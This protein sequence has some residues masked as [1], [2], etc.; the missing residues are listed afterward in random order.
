[1]NRRIFPQLLL[2]LL[3]L[4]SARLSPAQ[5]NL[6]EL[7][8]RVKP[9]IV[10]IVTYGA[11]GTALT[12]G[13]GFFLRPGQVVTNLHVIRGARR[14]EVKTLDGKGRVYQVS[15][16]LAVDEEGDLALLSVE[17]PSGRGRSSELA[18][19]LP[20]EGEKIFVIGNPLKLEGSV[21]DGI[22]S[23]VRELP[24]IG[25]IIQITAPI[26]HGNSGS[27]VFNLKGQ[28]VGVVTIKVTNGQNINL[29]I[30]AARVRQLRP[31]KRRLL[32]ELITRDKTGDPA[33]S[34]YKTGL[35]SLWLGNFDDALG[36]FENAVNKNPSRADA[37]VQV[38]YCR[39]K[40]GKND[41]AIKAYHQA[42]LL[43]PESD[44]IRNKLGDA[45]YYSGNLMEAIS[46]YKEAVRLR[47]QSADGYYNLAL[48]YFENGNHHE[49]LNAARL[50]KQLDER[51][52]AR[53]MSER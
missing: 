13:S 18:T 10:G 49:G 41:E 46:A 14:C 11:N 44:E 39:V 23:A 20:E 6:P 19:L 35:D 28:V 45:Y 37:W 27:P 5:E 3:V 22:V 36:Y 33:E 15:G 2:L 43:M 53:L 26:S 47:P 48:A 21:S 40:Q 4:F 16:L 30:G 51:L 25:K 17:L 7:V 9:A 24:N 29:A 31:G 38:G 42:V 52:F 32:A 34:L 1:M 12:T 50:L 8:R